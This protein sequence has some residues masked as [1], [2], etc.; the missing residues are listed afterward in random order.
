MAQIRKM[1]ALTAAI[2]G[3]AF[4]ASA[5]A[6]IVGTDSAGNSP[7]YTAG[8]GN[9]VTTEYNGLNGGTGFGAWV[10]TDTENYTG[11]GATSTSSTGNGGAFVNTSTNDATRNPAPVFDV[12][13]NG[14]PG[15]SSATGAAL[16]SSIETAFRPFAT[17]LT[18]AGSSF[19]FIESL[20]SL[21]PANAGAPTSQLGFELF[22][23]SGNV[24]LNLYTTGGAAGFSAIDATNSGNPYLLFSTDSG[25]SGA[26]SRALTIN[27]GAADTI[28]ITFNDNS[29]DYTITS[30]GHEGST[31]ADGGQI[32]MS[33]G[34]PA[35]FAIY[36][37]NGGNGSDIRVNG[38]TETV[39]PEPAS[40]AIGAL[41]LTGLLARRRR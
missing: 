41:T 21:R 22:D 16:G 29:G 19:S 26:S 25:H 24:L 11:T 38:L 31:F 14:N 32:N 30:G 40:I 37:N 33:T 6:S 12:Y 2:A 17:P 7:P 8:S 18:G 10:V 4:T 15:S 1:S 23:S 28:T 27:T 13:D 34:G 39:V 3:L 36:N 9:T 20:A 5:R 35:A